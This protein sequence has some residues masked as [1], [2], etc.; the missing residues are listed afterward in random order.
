MVNSNYYAM[1]SWP[2]VPFHSHRWPALLAAG[3]ARDGFLSSCFC[4]SCP[5]LHVAVKHTLGAHVLDPPMPAGAL[6]STQ[7]HCK[8]SLLKV[9]AGLE[10]VVEQI[11]PEVVME[12]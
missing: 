3:K 4:F 12:Q 6:L 10:P 9:Q 1:V 7:L 2:S 5:R 8:W 11:E